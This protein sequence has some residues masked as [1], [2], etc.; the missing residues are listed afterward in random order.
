[1]LRRQIV[2]T[3]SKVLFLQFGRR[4]LF[5]VGVL[6]VCFSFVAWFLVPGTLD[7]NRLLVSGLSASLATNVLLLSRILCKKGYDESFGTRKSVFRTPVIIL[8]L[9]LA[10]F[11]IATVTAPLRANNFYLSG[12]ATNSRELE[13][14]P[15]AS[16]NSQAVEVLRVWAAPG[17][18]QQLTL[19]TTWKDAGAWGL[20]LADVARHAANAYANE[21]QNKAE[22][23]R[24]IRRLLDAEF[25]RP[26]DNPIEIK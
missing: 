18:P 12:N 5:G 22:V 26:T 7:L 1:V 9:F 19:R 13:A 4:L 20:L 6:G 15:I 23:L 3:R 11:A 14:P 25:S 24:K 16:S 21:G 8:S 2:R 17:Q 10:V